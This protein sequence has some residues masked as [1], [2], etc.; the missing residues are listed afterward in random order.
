MKSPAAR[1]DVDIVKRVIANGRVYGLD[2]LLKGASRKPGATQE[3][4]RAR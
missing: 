2:E 4:A 1:T 3:G